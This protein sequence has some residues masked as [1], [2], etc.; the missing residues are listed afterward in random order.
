MKIKEFYN[1]HERGILAGLV[2]LFFVIPFLLIDYLALGKEAYS[3]SLFIDERIPFVSWFAVIYVSAYLLVLM[4]YFFVKAKVEFRR[5]A[6]IYLMILG[7][8]YLIFLVF[9]VQMLRPSLIG[10]GFFEMILGW[11][12]TIDPGYNCF[13]SLHVSAS[14]LAGMVCF[15]YNRKYK[16]FLAWAGLIMAS[17]L[18]VKQHYFLDVVSGLMVGLAGY[19]WFA[20]LKINKP[21]EN[22]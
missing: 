5:I 16:W 20:R 4:P 17:T 13:P 11:I 8:S 9:P 15:K 19:W 3:L 18:F 1:E 6:L 12:Y 7:F 14:F 22:G 21:L 2:V 10:G